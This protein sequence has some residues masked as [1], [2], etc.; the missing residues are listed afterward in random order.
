M[1]EEKQN[2]FTDYAECVYP[3]EYLE[4][5]TKCDLF[6]NGIFVYDTEVKTRDPPHT[7]FEPR[8]MFET[9]YPFFWGGKSKNK[10]R[11]GSPN[12]FRLG[13]YADMWIFWA[14]TQGRYRMNRNKQMFLYQGTDPWILR[15]KHGSENSWTQIPEHVAFA[16]LKAITE[17]CNQL[18]TAISQQVVRCH[19][20]S[21]YFKNTLINYRKIKEFVQFQSYKKPEHKNRRWSHQPRKV[22]GGKTEKEAASIRHPQESV[23]R[24]LCDYHMWLPTVRVTARGRR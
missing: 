4:R 12:L 17:T 11:H 21:V 16:T 5:R 20:R 14:V 2:P 8:N 19:G 13:Q 9:M 15:L 3:W 23:H 24:M 1:D 18:Y 22:G 6:K 7:E 10:V